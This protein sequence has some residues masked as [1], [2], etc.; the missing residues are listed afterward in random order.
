VFI[1]GAAVQWL[2][3]GLGVIRSAAETEALAA[4]VPDTGGVYFVPAFAG[5]GA[6]YWNPYARGTIV[7]LTRGTTLPHLV[8]ATLEAIAYQTR[9][10]V[11]AMDADVLSA[12]QEAGGAGQ[13]ELSSLKVD[14]GAVKNDFLCQFQSDLL[15][16]PVVRPTVEET[17]ALGAAY[18]AGLAVGYWR[19]PEEIRR[20]W[21]AERV[22][23]PQMSAERRQK[24]YA[25]W[26]QA[27]QCALSWAG[28]VA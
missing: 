19:D 16:M 13:A 20:L 24:L 7:G 10:V 14:G 17:T 15:G 22:F 21:K 5:L 3:D 6:P 12:G 28:R 25:G 8:R 18:A 4:S 23:T 11:E 27:V 9:D 2:R 26:K 1:T